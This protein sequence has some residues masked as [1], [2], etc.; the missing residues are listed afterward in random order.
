MKRYA[1]SVSRWWIVV[2][3]IS[4]NIIPSRVL[5]AQIPYTVPLV[6]N[7]NQIAIVIEGQIQILDATTGELIHQLN[8]AWGDIS[9]TAWSP[10]S[11]FLAVAGATGKVDIWDMELS[12]WIQSLQLE[13]P[14]SVL[15]WAQTNNQIVTIGGDVA[16]NLN[17][18][19]VS[20]GMRTASQRGGAALNAEYDPTGHYLALHTSLSLYVLD[21]TTFTVLLA[22][23]YAECCDNQ[24]STLSWKPDGTR[25][26]TGSINGLITVWDA[27]TLS[28]LNQFAANPYYVQDSRDVPDLSLSWVRDVAFGADGTIQAVSGDG[29]LRL[30]ATNGELI[31]EAQTG[32]LETAAWSPYGARLAVQRS[33]N[34]SRAANGEALTSSDAIMQIITPFASPERLQAIA[35][36]CGAPLTVNRQLDSAIDA[37]DMTS[38]I[39]Q[40]ESLPTE[41]IPPA[42]AADL[43]AVA[44]A[45]QAQ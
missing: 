35:E 27:T 11:R 44:E 18:W 38:L 42:C 21:A 2:L 43:I 32:I 36:Q 22:S 10:D 33:Q 24:L 31:A 4:I 9:A 12:D 17:V 6:W 1:M 3:V 13:Y 37:A 25:I 14:A 8:N 20:T 23:P 15:I 16:E 28:P 5:Q 34:V 41:T 26:V 19:D 30:W 40:V 45:I 7:E 39:A 29:T